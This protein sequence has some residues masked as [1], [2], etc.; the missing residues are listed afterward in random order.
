MLSSVSRR[1]NQSKNLVV[2]VEIGLVDIVFD[3]VDEEGVRAVVRIM[4]FN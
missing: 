2:D 1:R 3:V 4:V